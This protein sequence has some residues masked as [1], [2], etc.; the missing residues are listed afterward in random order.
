[1]IWFTTYACYSTVHKYF[2]AFWL[3]PDPNDRAQNNLHNGRT[4]KEAISPATP[5]YP[6]LVKTVT[7]GWHNGI[8]MGIH[9]NAKI[10]KTNTHNRMTLSYIYIYICQY[11]YLIYSHL[12]EFGQQHNYFCKNLKIGYSFRDFKLLPWSRRELC[13]SGSLTFW[14]RNYFFNFSTPCI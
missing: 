6:N 3:S 7:K 1:M 8:K 9:V 12:S 4:V 2:T 5:S 14:C 11:C 13:S 10:L